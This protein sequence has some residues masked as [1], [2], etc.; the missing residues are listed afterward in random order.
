MPQADPQKSNTERTATFFAVIISILIVGG[1]TW[2]IVAGKIAEQ[3]ENE[4]L[5]SKIVINDPSLISKVE[6]QKNDE[7]IIGLKLTATEKFNSISP[8]EQ[9]DLMFKAA[10]GHGFDA[11]ALR[12]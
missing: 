11:R 12:N 9:F 1:G 7:K 10:Y 4:A 2:S 8:Y 3:K 6:V 5:V